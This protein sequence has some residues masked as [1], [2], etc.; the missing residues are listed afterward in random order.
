[1]S[2][3]SSFWTLKFHEL[4]NDIK[5]SLI[6]WVLTPAITLW[7]FK[8]PSG[9]QLPRWELNWE[10]G[11]SSPHTF[12]HSR[13]HEMWFP[14]SLLARTFASPCLDREPKAKVAT[15][16]PTRGRGQCPHWQL[17][18]VSSMQL[19]SFRSL[20]ICRAPK[21]LVDPLEGPSLRQCGRSWNLGHDPDFQH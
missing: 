18:I 16:S 13:E 14:N 6:P 21:S 7:R 2:H 12:L 9:L 10:C 4:S 15:F 19:L 20:A 3:A 8:S 1:M 17:E 5:N 11:G